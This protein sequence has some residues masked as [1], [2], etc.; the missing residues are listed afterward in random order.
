MSGT[1][2]THRE[3]HIQILVGRP[4]VMRLPGRPRLKWEININ[5]DLKV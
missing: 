3:I 2:S 4:E 5:M 1:C